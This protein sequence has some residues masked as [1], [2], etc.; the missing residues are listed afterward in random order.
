[1]R[2]VEQVRRCQRSVLRSFRAEAAQAAGRTGTDSLPL[3]TAQEKQRFE[4]R[5]DGSGW[6]SGGAP[7]R[8]GYE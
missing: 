6:K 7:A 2:I 8:G 1:M 4:S 3:M 5:A